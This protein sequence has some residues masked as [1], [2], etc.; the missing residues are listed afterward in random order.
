MR[1]LAGG[2]G[3]AGGSGVF[4]L[5]RWAAAA[6]LV[7]GLGTAEAEVPKLPP[8][9]KLV[10]EGSGPMEK[11]TRIERVPGAKLAPR[12]SILALANETGAGKAAELSTELMNQG[13]GLFG[14]GFGAVSSGNTFLVHGL[15][16]NSL[17][18]LDTAFTWAGLVTTAISAANDFANDRPTEGV[19]GSLKGF[20]GFAISNWGWSAVQ[21]GGISL[22]FVDITFREW[23]KGTVNAGL[24]NFRKVYRESFRDD[25]RGVN[26]WKRVAWE[27]YLVAEQ[28]QDKK[29][30]P[31]ANVFGTLMQAEIARYTA[32]EF[33]PEMLLNWDKAK[34]GW[35]MLGDQARVEEALAKEY[36][37][38]IEAM[39]L[40]RV[41]P[42]LARKAGERSV[43]RM[44]AKLN[45]D[46]V[47]DL[48][49][50]VVL[51]VLAWGAPEGAEVSVPL[52]QGKPW[53]GTLD[54][55]G[56]FRMEFT[57]FAFVKAGL[58]GKVILRRDGGEETRDV[59]I[60]GG[61]M[62]AIFGEPQAA[63]ISRFKLVD[64]PRACILT[65]RDAQT[66]KLINLRTMGLPA[67]ADSQLDMAVLPSGTVIAGAYDG[68]AG[69]WTSAA[70]GQWH[71]GNELLLSRSP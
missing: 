32:R 71:L 12:A 57:R 68:A 58:P 48:N 6:A 11:I 7:M 44:V 39:L 41:Y 64:G 38:E 51:E 3:L 25:P 65:E 21:V 20:M 22:Y 54:A 67:L 28:W 56:A 46:L 50:I 42:E 29:R 55:T 18:S 61:K 13:I 26:E 15:Q 69:K 37:T 40:T 59:R 31:A 70:P 49:K 62:V 24:D 10:T 16:I 35:G 23:A 9:L 8:F 36:A 2:R 34:V 47:P 60:V 27:K 4:G 43:A 1:D 19:A 66:G 45:A 53:G 33:T 52:V 63:I 30:D 17:G 5:G 14:D